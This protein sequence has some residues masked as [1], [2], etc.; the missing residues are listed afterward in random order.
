ME[1]YW[2]IFWFIVFG[3]GGGFLVIFP[4]LISDSNSDYSPLSFAIIG[5]GLGIIIYFLIIILF[6]LGPV[7]VT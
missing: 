4:L 1:W 6:L 2:Y 3:I 5:V 7:K